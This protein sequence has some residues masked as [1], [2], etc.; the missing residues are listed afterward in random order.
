VFQANQDEV[1]PLIPPPAM[2]KLNEMFRNLTRI[3]SNI[4]TL[5]IIQS[6]LERL[7]YTVVLY[8]IDTFPVR[9]N[10]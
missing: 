2:P 3:T 8:H 6:T 5:Q 10:N 4:T 7:E 1:V 9:Y